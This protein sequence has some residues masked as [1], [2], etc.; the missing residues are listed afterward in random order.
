MIHVWCISFPS[1]LP[2]RT[3]PL[4]PRLANHIPVP[5]H[6]QVARFGT[7]GS[8]LLWSQRTGLM[9]K[10]IQQF[11]ACGLA[12]RF[13]FRIWNGKYPMMM[14]V[15]GKSYQTKV[16]HRLQFRGNGK[17]CFKNATLREEN[18]EVQTETEI[19]R[20]TERE[21]I[22]RT[23]GS[24][25]LPQAPNSLIPAPPIIIPPPVLTCRSLAFS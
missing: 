2:S 13:S 16:P 25:E 1:A 5:S 17:K 12:K 4:Y 19:M 20:V 24:P 18:G 14:P 9:T 23:E 10:K 15:M 21:R 7:T 6:T 3:D 8:H 11:K 22:T